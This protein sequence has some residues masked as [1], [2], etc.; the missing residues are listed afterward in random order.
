VITEKIK[1]ISKEKEG[2]DREAKREVIK[3]NNSWYLRLLGYWEDG[4]K[5]R[6]LSGK[7]KDI[8]LRRL[9]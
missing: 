6:D 8:Y 1:K 7:K 5:R 3:R 9:E 4:D 2:R